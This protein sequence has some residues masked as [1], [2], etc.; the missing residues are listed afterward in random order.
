MQ[1]GDGN[2][3]LMGLEGRD[4]M[5]GGAGSDI[6][7]GG[8]GIDDVNGNLGND[9][10]LIVGEDVGL[11]G[12]GIDVCHFGNGSE[13]AQLRSCEAEQSLGAEWN[14]VSGRFDDIWDYWDI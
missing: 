5:R 6:V 1:G 13:A 2:D 10:M 9:N 4:W 14:D 8:A 12:F 3:I 7:I 11:G